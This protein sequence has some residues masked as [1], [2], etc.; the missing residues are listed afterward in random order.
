VVTEVTVRLDLHEAI[1]VMEHGSPMRSFDT[2]ELYKAIN[3]TVTQ[4]YYIFSSEEAVVTVGAHDG[5]VSAH[6]PQP[7]AA[8]GFDVIDAGRGG[9]R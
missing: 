8:I 9:L 7:P 5:A 2:V 3:P 1:A 4:P 6:R